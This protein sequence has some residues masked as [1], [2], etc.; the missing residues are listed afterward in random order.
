MTITVAPEVL[1]IINKVGG[2]ILTP[3]QLLVYPVVE[4]DGNIPPWDLASSHTIDVVL[5]TLLL[6]GL[7]T[8][9]TLLAFVVVKEGALFLAG[10]L[11]VYQAR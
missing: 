8:S 9:S 5:R 2:M 1:T 6:S 7:M 4:L 3:A 11:E 10:H